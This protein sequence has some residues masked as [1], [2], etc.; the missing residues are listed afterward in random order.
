MKT[1]FSILLRFVMPL[2]ITAAISTQ[3]H[4]QMQTR[5]VENPDRNIWQ[6]RNFANEYSLSYVTVPLGQVPANKRLILD[7]VS[8]RWLLPQGQT[9]HCYVTLGHPSLADFDLQVPATAGT[10]PIGPRVIKLI[11]QPVRMYIDQGNVAIACMRTTNEQGQMTLSV[12]AVGHLV[13][14]P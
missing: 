11:S 9:G 4:A 8:L 10:N 7:F 6:V 5:D 14:R 12:T 2:L 3:A 1:R 13:D